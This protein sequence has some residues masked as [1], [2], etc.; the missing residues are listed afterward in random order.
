MSLRRVLAVAV[1]AG[2]LCCASAFAA[3]PT[4]TAAPAAGNATTVAPP[5]PM[6]WQV[7]RGENR[8]YLLG[9]FHLL[10]ENDYPFH[11]D[12]DAA[13]EDA[14]K[15]I[16]EVHPDEVDDPAILAAAME[17]V[18]GYAPGQSFDTVVPAA[19]RE[20][21]EAL[22]QMAGQDP[23]ALR[24]SEPW[25]L[26]LGMSV[27]IAQALGFKGE[28]GMDKRLMGRAGESG[29][30]VAGLETL[31]FQLVALDSVPYEEQVKGLDQ[32]VS[33]MPKA[34]REMQELHARWRQ[35][36]VA[37]LDRGM[38]AEMAEKTPVSYRLI[39]TDRN[40]AWLPQVEARLS[41]PNGDDTLVVVGALH[42]LG[43]DGLVEM[44]RARGYDVQRICSACAP[45]TP[46]V[47][48]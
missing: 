15:L 13:F 43:K 7:T 29:K 14:E 39:N 20:K 41:A 1:S 33:D 4:P 17:K 19:T 2:L 34:V 26:S 38:R 35:G 10:L 37:G 40:K 9:S 18:A 47:R 28:H 21:L 3:P 24:E 46:D 30:H 32:M 31:E 12:V 6:L 27:G 45:G 42:L 11:P 23:A 22:S 48:N 8:V 5:V 25:M 36:D 44:L 16:F